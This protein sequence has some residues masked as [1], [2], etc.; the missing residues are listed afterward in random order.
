MDEKVLIIKTDKRKIVIKI[1]VMG[2]VEM[3]VSS[4]S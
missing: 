4:N 1:I 2:K 3:N